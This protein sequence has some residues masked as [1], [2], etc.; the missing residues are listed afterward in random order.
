M[1]GQRL[2]MRQIR[3]I[4]RQKWALGRSHREVARSLGLS[5]GAVSTTQ[6]RAR[7]AGLDW[8]A[9]ETL[10]EPELERRLYRMAEGDDACRP[11]PD[12]AW[13]H[14]ERQRVGVTLE[15][16]HLEYLEQHPDGYRYTQ[17]CEYYR[18]WCQKQRLSMRQPHRAGEKLFVDYAGKKPRIVNP[19]TGEEQE[20]ELFVAV[21]GASSFTYAEATRSQRSADFIASHTRALEYFGGVPELVIPDQLK[22]GVVRACRYEPGLQRTYAEWAEH[23]GTAVLPARPKKPRDKAKVEV[24]V[25][26]AER[27]ILARLRNETFFSLAALNARIRELL[28]DLNDRVMRAYGQTRRQRFE[29]LDR[30]VLRPLPTQ[31]FTFAEWKQAR[32]NIDYHVVFEKHFYSV[33]YALVHE[34]VE[35][36]AT[37]RTVEAFHRG[38]RV[39]SHRRSRQPGGYTTDPAHMPKSHQKHLQW[40]PSRLIHWAGTIGPKTAALVEAILADRPHPEQGYRS[41]LG[42]LRLAKQY[43]EERLEA[44]C[45]RAVAVRARSYRHVASILKNGLDRQP[46]A[47]DEEK[48]TPP[49]AAHEN[50]RGRDYYH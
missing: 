10:S 32:V 43:G 7:E 28:T 22:S 31:P 23:Y 5:V 13:L 14:T 25:Q 29:Q 3:E 21:L 34:A 19:V 16:L 11:L 17:F 24:A 41:C 50:V 12:F 48:T 44:A 26:V 15:L 20:V 46:W 30:P 38:Q 37:E 6:K 18:R 9:V 47:E 8:A 35:I 49:S 33:P 4:L 2:F 40:T 36:R 39:A 1:A 27:W 45:E 42:I